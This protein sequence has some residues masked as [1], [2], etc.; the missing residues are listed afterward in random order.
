MGLGDPV[1]MTLQLLFMVG[2]HLHLHM[3]NLARTILDHIRQSNDQPVL[4]A[5]RLS[6]GQSKETLLVLL[7]EVFT[8]NVQLRIQVVFL[9]TSRLVSGKERSLKLPLLDLFEVDDLHEDGLQHPKGP[10]SVSIQLLASKVLQELNRSHILVAFPSHSDLMCKFI[11]HGGSVASPLQAHESHESGVIPAVNNLFL[12]H[13]LQLP[14]GEEVVA[15]VQARVL[16]DYWP[17]DVQ[18]FQQPVVRLSPDLK[19]QAAQ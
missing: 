9:G 19:L 6:W 17:V 11:D 12:N 18:G 4:E 2:K 13:L 8:L 5:H 1:D 14:L 15:D 10:R 16:P 7:R 3:V